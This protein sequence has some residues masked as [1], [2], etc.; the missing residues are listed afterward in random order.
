MALPTSLIVIFNTELI[1]NLSSWFLSIVGFLFFSFSLINQENTRNIENTN[2]K[3]S[4][5]N[6]MK[7]MFIANMSHEL[8][9]PISNILGLCILLKKLNIEE[10]NNIELMGKKLIGLVDNILFFSQSKFS[11]LKLSNENFTL[12]NLMYNLFQTIKHKLIDKNITLMINNQNIE[13]YL[14]NNDNNDNQ[15][16]YGDINKI[17]RILINL[18]VNAIKFS[19]EDSNILINVTKHKT[20][21]DKIRFDFS[22]IDYGIGI[23]KNNLSK[24]FL[25]FIQADISTTRKFGGNGLGLAICSELV[26]KLSGDIMVE[27]KLGVGSKF[28]FNIVVNKENI[29]EKIDIVISPLSSSNSNKS[30]NS[31]DYEIEFSNIIKNKLINI[32]FKNQSQQIIDLFKILLINYENITF[33][34]DKPADLVIVKGE[35]K[36]SGNEIV[37]ECSKNQINNFDFLKIPFTPNNFYKKLLNIL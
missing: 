4:Q 18:T 11:Q 27:S 23:D 5:L 13:E 28:Y 33:D 2:T 6:E 19:H 21:F 12:N 24:I 20:E 29:E 16:F 32:N 26:H 25:P 8:K 34:N 37:L 1:T 31:N 36:K 9:T 14:N 35:Y 30:D 17:E 15:V 3:L 10:I 22:V 7:S